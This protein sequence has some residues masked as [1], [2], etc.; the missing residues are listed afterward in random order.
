MLIEQ[1]DAGCFRLQEALDLGVG[2]QPFFLVYRRA[3][4]VD[5]LIQSGHTRVPLP[6]PTARLSMVEGMQD[7]ISIECRVIPPT[8]NKPVR[9]FALT[10]EELVIGRSWV[11]DLEVGA[12]PDLGEHLSHGFRELPVERT[13]LKIWDP[14]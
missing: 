7:G 6:D 14:G 10:L 9:R 8:A 5:E 4:G 1:E 11:P 3:P 12:Q 13:N 2:C